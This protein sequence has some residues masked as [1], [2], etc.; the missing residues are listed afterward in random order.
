MSE[1]DSRTPDETEQLAELARRADRARAGLG[2]P[3]NPL[4]PIGAGAMQAVED[5]ARAYAARDKLFDD[6]GQFH[7]WECRGPCE[8]HI[9]LQCVL[10]RA[11]APR[12]KRE[13]DERDRLARQAKHLRA[14]EQS[15]PSWA[16]GGF[17]RSGTGD[18][19]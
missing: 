14:K 19:Y 12:R 16:S 10:C 9:S 6:T 2:V 4:Q 5:C 11:D 8:W 1:T 15:A 13:Q 3:P 17:R 7:C 18:D